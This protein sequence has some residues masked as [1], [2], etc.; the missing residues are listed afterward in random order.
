M[1]NL[2]KIFNPK[3]VAIIGA[4]SKEKSVGS[5]LVKNILIGK[6]ER[7]IFFV[8][9]NQAEILGNKVFGKISD[10]HE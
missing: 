1:K 7:A 6:D 4:S 3:T 8:N 9:I 2:H 5:G 10:I